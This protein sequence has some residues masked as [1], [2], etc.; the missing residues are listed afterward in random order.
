MKN[1]YTSFIPVAIVALSIYSI[2][3]GLS[4]ADIHYG[5]S[6]MVAGAIGLAIAT[7]IVMY[8]AQVAE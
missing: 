6:N 5:I 8:N 1:I 2:N 7:G 4:K 3:V